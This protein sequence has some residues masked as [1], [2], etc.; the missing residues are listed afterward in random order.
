[1]FKSITKILLYAG[2]EKDKYNK[3]KSELAESNRK[4]LSVYSLMAS[5]A[6][7]CMTAASFFEESLVK[8][9]PTYIVCC[10]ICTIIFVVVRWFSK[11]K[12]GVIY[13][14]VYV[15]TALFLAFGINL[16][17]FVEPNEVTASYTV[18]VFAVPLLFVDRPL[19][20]NIV[21]LLSMIAYFICA[22]MTQDE[23]MFGYNASNVIPY[24]ALGIIVSSYMMKIKAERYSF[25]LDNKYLSESDQLTGLLNRRSYEHNIQSL[26]ESE[27]AAGTLICAFDLNGL[28][29]V[30]DT[31]GHRAG[32]ELLQGAANCIDGVFGQYGTC[33]RTGGDEFMAILSGPYPTENELE[34]M[35]NA[36]TRSWKGSLVSGMSISCGFAKIESSEN[37]EAAIYNADKAMYTAKSNYYRNNGIDRRKA[38]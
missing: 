31:L 33:Y 29:T 5:I 18:L 30:N 20:M 2:L 24:G 23:I 9:I 11:G 36:R 1:M 15:F 25:E 21:L 13:S 28:K 35:L 34:E 26:R 38:R 32:D 17:T 14:C 8:N 10:I 27:N 37:I 7:L 12:H 6:L 3:V 16:G 4:N 22:A 19:R